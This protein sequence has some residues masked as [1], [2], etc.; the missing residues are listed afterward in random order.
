MSSRFFRFAWLASPIVALAFAG[1][2]TIAGNVLKESRDGFNQAAQITNAEQLLRN[3]VRLRYAQSPYFLEISSVS[4]SA[5]MAGG[6]G[7][8]VNTVSTVP[9]F[10][11]NLTLS[12]SL[13]YSQTPSFV[14]QPLTGEKL[15][16]QLLRPVDLRTLALLR[17]AGWDLRDI[18]IVLVDS[19][20]G[21]PNAPAATQFAPPSVPDNADFRRVVDLIDQLEDAGL[22]QLGIEPGVPSPDPRG[23]IVLSLQIDKQAAGRAEVAELTRRL[24]LDPKNLTYRLAAAATGGGGQTIVVKPR[25]VLAA[26]RYLSKG[27]EIPQADRAAGNV[28]QVSV[29]GEVV[30]WTKLMSGIFTVRSSEVPP[31]NAYVSIRHERHWFFIDPADL[32]A[33]QSFALLETV[34]ALQ[35]GDVPPITTVLTLPIAR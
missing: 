19:I 4:T 29:D 14:F 16:R 33:K 32:A 7:S 11:F 31:A 15:G 24:G 30:D 18:L 22:V 35:G 34:F 21:I 13:S 27:I 23:D 5:T 2:S 25:S 28:P 8:G 26:M 6:L 3:L 10:D 1:C 20:N 17:T 12:P 9:G